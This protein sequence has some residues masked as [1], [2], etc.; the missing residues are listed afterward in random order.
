M[1]LPFRLALP[2]IA[3]IMLASLARGQ[4][5]APA[6]TVPDT[7]TYPYRTGFNPSMMRN[8]DGTTYAPAPAPAPCPGGACPAPAP[9]PVVHPQHHGHGKCIVYSPQNTVCVPCACEVCRCATVN[10]CNAPVVVPVCP[11]CGCCPCRCPVVCQPVHVVY[12][13]HCGWYPGKLIGRLF[14]R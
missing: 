2:F 1:R 9:V 5:P 3:L 6:P 4:T 10:A 11:A 12:R 7:G 8:P 13:R 14:C